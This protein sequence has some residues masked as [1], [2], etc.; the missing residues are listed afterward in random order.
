MKS[1]AEL[2]AV[3]EQVAP[4]LA[5]R[6]N[7]EAETKVLVGMGTCGIAAGA[8]AVLGAFVEEIAKEGLHH[9]MVTQ[10]GCMGLCQFEPT[11]E[12]VT[13]GGKVTYGNMTPEKAVTVVQQHL[14]GGQ[15]VSE[16]LVG[17]N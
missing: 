4:A 11:V 5:I 17:T 9:I 12:V 2:Q 10:T 3:K 14:A 6:Q 8:K 16:Y 1:L 15:A 13:A 7:A